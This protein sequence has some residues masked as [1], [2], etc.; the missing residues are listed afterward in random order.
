MPG[1]GKIEF[2]E[3]KK[4]EP[5]SDEI[6]IKILKIGICGSDIH[7]YYG[8]HPYT[9]YPIVQGHE[10]SGI[11]EKTGPDVI[12]FQVGDIVTI[13]PQIVCGECYCCKNG[14][15]NI[16]DDLKVMGFQTNGA[17]QEYFVVKQDW[18]IKL[19]K[20]ISPDEGALIEPLAVAVHA[21]KKAGEVKG[22]NII[23]LGAGTIGNLT[24]QTA[25]AFGAKKVIITDIND[26]RLGIAKKCGIDAT[27][28]PERQ[29]LGEAITREF[30]ISRADIIFE[31]VGSEKTLTTAV[32]NAR[33]GSLIIIVGVFSSRPEVDMGLV[34]DRELTISG[35]LMYRRED[36]IDAIEFVSGG[37]ILLKKIISDEFSFKDYIKAYQY[38]ENN[39]K[40]VMKVLVSLQ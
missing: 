38:I 8:K 12:G 39:R 10:V 19:P 35:T 1:P 14:M 25:K 4:P 29:D 28:N 2:K 18:A 7:V 31:C 40:K 3:I 11:V 32:T 24:A 6:L 13:M 37:K 16:C 23:V 30:G 20:N 26:Y 9:S 36:F 5:A 22:K 33:K 34:Q 15:Y 17:A 21:N 27:L